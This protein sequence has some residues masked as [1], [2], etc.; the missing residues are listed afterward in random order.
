[1]STPWAVE[2]EWT[3]QTAVILASGPSLTRAQCDAVR[4][5]ARVIAVSNQGIDTENSDTGEMIPALAPWADVLY[6]A[7][8]KWWR[9]YQARALKFAG[10]KVALRCTLPWPEVFCLQQSFDH[11]CFDPRPTHIVSG[12]NSGYQAV[13]LAVHLGATRIVLLGFDMKDG[14][15]GRR[16]WFGNHPGRLNSRG[17]YRGW[18]SAFEK[19]SKLLKHRN[20]DVINCT[21]DSALK[22]FR[23]APLKDVFGC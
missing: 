13:H 21:P 8:A 17:N 5:K 22:S 23:R 10:R 14:R 4:G 6:A 20:I 7:D 11:A 12:G 3:G 2:P 16:H 15:N 19:F 18:L 1:M 9:S